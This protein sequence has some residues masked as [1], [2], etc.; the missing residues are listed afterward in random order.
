MAIKTALREAGVTHDQIDVFNCHATSTP[1]G[2]LSE[3]QCIKAI[4][5]KAVITANKGNIGHGVAAACAMET[6]LALISLK[7]QILPNIRNLD[8]PLDSE[9]NFCRKVS[10]MDFST[11]VK[12][13]LVFGGLNYSIVLN[14]FIN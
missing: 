3:A 11:V 12:N 2:D 13:S 4:T 6:S 1:K 8:S 10:P 7:E 9:L 5:D 14:K